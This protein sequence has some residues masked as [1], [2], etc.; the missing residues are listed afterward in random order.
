MASVT[1]AIRKAVAREKGKRQVDIVQA[2]NLIKSLN[3]VLSNEL[4][5]LIRRT[6]S[7]RR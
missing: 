5:K 2:R 6:K 7:L 4:Y 1:E 3:I